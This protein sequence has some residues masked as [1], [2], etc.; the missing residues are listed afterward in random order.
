[1][2]NNTV[3][4]RIAKFAPFDTSDFNGEV[5]EPAVFEN[6][7]APED[8]SVADTPR[9]DNV[10]LLPRADDAERSPV[11]KSKKQKRTGKKTEKSP[12]PAQQADIDLADPSQ[13]AEAIARYKSLNTSILEM[14]AEK[15]RLENELTEAH[16]RLEE[17]EEE[18]SILSEEFEQ[19]SK[20]LKFATDHGI[21]GFK[22]LA[23]RFLQGFAAVAGGSIVFAYLFF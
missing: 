4:G 16:S 13:V 10:A 22:V 14:A 11:R 19:Q 1:M 9:A 3:L 17:A 12:Q 8:K 6:Q 2:T 7:F 23:K 20:M 18:L 5:I 21:V 15:V